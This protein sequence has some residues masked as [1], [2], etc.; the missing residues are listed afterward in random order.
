MDIAKA[1]ADAIGE[2]VQKIVNDEAKQA[3]DRVD[4]RVRDMGAR[5]AAGVIKWHD[6]ATFSDRVVV[7]IKMPPP[8][9]LKS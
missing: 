5:I 8:E 9:E 1:I 3:A 2:E 4:Q 7:T 6:M